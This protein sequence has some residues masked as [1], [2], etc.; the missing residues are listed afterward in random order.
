MSDY[1]FIKNRLS[2]SFTGVLLVSMFVSVAGWSQTN[3]NR[4][5]GSLVKPAL[6]QVAPYDLSKDKVVYVVTDAHLD[7]QWLYDMQRTIS[8]FIPKTLRENFV[9]FEKYPGYVF[10]FEGAYRYWLTKQKYPADYA[11]LKTYV[12]SGNW[13]VAGG[14][15]EMADVNIPSAEALMRQ[16]L[17]GNGFFMD[18]FN[19]KSIQV[20]LPDNFGF[21]WALPTIA[22]HMG[23]KG[24]SGMRLANCNPR[25]LSPICKWLGPD[26]SYLIAICKTGDYAN[27][28]PLLNI[29]VNGD[30]TS[31][32][33]KGALWATWKYF[34]PRG[35]RGGTPADSSVKRLMARI[36]DNPNQTIKFT[37]ASSD[38]FFL[39]LSQ[40]QINSLPVYNGEYHLPWAGSWTS[41]A[42]MKLKNRQNEQRALAAEHAAVIA[43]AFTSSTYPSQKLWLAWFRLLER[44]FHDDICGTSIQAADAFS[45]LQYDSCYTE[46]THVLVDATNR[47]SNALDTRATKKDRIPIVLFNQLS[48]DRNDIV[49]TIVNFGSSAPVGIKVFNQDGKEVPAQIVRKDGQN[50]VIAFVAHVPSVSY[51]VYEVMSVN[52]AIPHN[53]N[54]KIDAE[55]GILE[56]N[57]YKVTVDDKGDI[58]SILDKKS[59]QQLLSA[60]SRLEGRATTG[61]AYNISRNVMLSPAKWYVDESVVKTVAENGPARVSLKITRTKDG[62]TYTQ[63][64]R[65]AADAAG[66]SVLVDNTV[67]WKSEK[68]VLSVSFPMTCTNQN[69]TYDLGIGTIQRQNINADPGRYDHVAQQ[70]ADITNQ[71]NKYGLSILNDCKYGWHMPD[72]SSLYLELINGGTGGWG[73]YEG[74]HYVHNFKYAF[75]GH[76]GDWT[77]GTVSEAARLNQP[78]LAFPTTAHKGTAG[79]VLSFLNTNSPQMVVMALKKAEKGNEFIV[80]VREA[81]GK[82]L[83]GAKITFASEILSAKEVMGSEEPKPDGKVTVSGKDMV[84]DLTP[85]QPK[86]FS[87]TLK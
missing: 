2:I 71:N 39:D 80:R 46:F 3:Q 59:R 12:A 27:Q 58:S 24:L 35:D 83:Q 20:M 64:V 7:T 6:I 45:Y 72:N 8:E 66:T 40:S 17:Y 44:E 28:T 30:A 75:Y 87:F 76:S 81:S 37:N 63:Y 34:G 55:T 73:K 52:K 85:Y 5:D 11:R 18:E 41:N 51:T 31:T 82:A 19:K 60:S 57:Y 43:N 68:T 54:L 70:W 79:K 84:F 32:D 67:D 56:N 21:T 86:T 29:T 1:N 23:M 22:S 69:A 77:N 50:A 16:F 78:I 74:D 14:M 49:E 9:L 13:S 47:F 62:S 4:L 65:L 36:A 26:G 53:P 10:N 15:V 25:P 38:Q 61:D 48:T 33:T 42:M